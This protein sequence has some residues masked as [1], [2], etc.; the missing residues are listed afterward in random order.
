[1][2]PYYRLNTEEL[3]ENLQSNKQGLSSDEIR[4]RISIYGPNELKTKAK[5]PAWIMFLNQFR[6]FMIL[7]L[8][9]ASILS[10]VL[11]D[12]TDTFIILGIILINAF[13]GFYQEY[14]AEKA[15]EA[16]KQ[17]A[18][19][20]IQVIRN[21]HSQIVNSTELVPG[22]LVLLES[23]NVV[24]AD[25]R[26]IQNFSLRVD[27]SSLTGESMPIDKT[28]H[29]ITEN[30][31][32]LAEQMNMI[33][34]GT[35]VTHGRA[36]AVVCTTGMQTELGRI[37]GLLQEE[38]LKTPLQDRM[39][40]FG[41]SLSYLILF[42]CF[43]LFVAGWLR[44]EEPFGL[45]LISI[46][47]A[48]AAI[49]EALPVLIMIALA[50]GASRL[51]R[52]NALIRKLPAVETLGSVSI[53][54]SDKTGTL[55]QNK[56]KVEF[57]HE[58]PL[59]EKK[60]GRSMLVTAMAL[61]HDVTLDPS[62][63]LIGEPTEKA[64]L[65]KVIEDLGVEH[66]RDLVAEFPRI[67]E[68]PFDSDR[69]C[70][71]TVHDDHGR[72]LVITKGAFDS[73]SE[74]LRH[75]SEQEELMEI[76]EKWAQQ[77]IRV[78]AYSFRTLDKL[79]SP[80][81]YKLIEHEQLFV[82]LVGLLD[83]ARDEVPESIAI[84]KKAGIIPVM[85][86]GDH[87]AT[88]MYIARKIGILD[89]SDRLISGSDFRAMDKEE[90]LEQVDEIKV[91]ARVT[92]EQKL[93]IVRNLQSKGHIVAM[94]GDGVNDAASLKA[95][96]IGVAMGINGTDVSKEA[97]D[98]ILLDDNF[99]TIVKAV[100]EGRRVYDNIRKFI[101]YIMTCNSAEI[102]T[103]LLAPLIGLPIPLLPVHLLWINLV[104]DG[105]PALALARERG[106]T[107]IMHRPPRKPS[108]SIFA[109][110]MAYHIIWVGLLMAG[111]TLATQAWAYS[112]GL[113]SWQTMV[114]SV[115]AFSQLGHVL[116]VKSDKTFLYEQ[117]LFSNMNMVWA[118]TSTFVLQMLIIYTP[119]MNALF[120]TQPLS[121]KELAICLLLS[122]VVF[123]AVEFEK[124]VRYKKKMK[125]E[126]PK[127]NGLR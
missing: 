121:F 108:E 114:F 55:T 21:G 87:P 67:A 123:H 45:L 43:I 68:L 120:K 122:V 39:T 36:L 8:A 99:T 37:A 28:D 70:M 80:F 46:S 31:V 51:A 90:I 104:T 7:I 96:N 18:M 77:G 64:L 35:L 82:G 34:K 11:G 4:K 16:L 92:P 23:G 3:L 103:I 105:F 74:I 75:K 58:F 41:K 20:Y 118:I 47:L 89:G 15:L 100:Q 76:S 94:T 111:I 33:F 32:I 27:E 44:G 65:V 42:I 56:M 9:M 115:L 95:S 53:I 6:D 73:I 50:S 109:E 125:S 26:V 59:C 13:V 57:L 79:P 54:C 66:Y 98:M 110:G 112:K 124:W 85:I 63:Q 2:V 38:K 71:T 107:D 48:V 22:D 81:E 127:E 12:L 30:D 119:A 14:H 24:P 17:L 61:N 93:Q 102:W 1:M 72:F 116:A 25:M 40:R 86:T 52:K 97:S 101:K 5:T 126:K 29:Q 19:S 78:M 84:C 49:P 62:D 83:P 106:E 113:E 117:G 91:Y 60:S 69:K 10:G 88:A